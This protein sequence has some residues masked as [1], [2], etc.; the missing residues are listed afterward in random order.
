M[1]QGSFQAGLAAFTEQARKKADKNVRK[2]ILACL[3]G[4]IS[5]SPVDTGSFRLNWNIQ[6]KSPDLST[7]EYTG[8]PPKKKEPKPATMS[9]VN[10]ALTITYDMGD[11]VYIS[12]A[13][14]YANSIESGHSEQARIGVVA[15]T[16]REVESKIAGGALD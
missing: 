15:P 16:I 10:D 14:P 9:E 6:A 4:C 3:Q 12:N 13:L 11:L 2:T 7:K 1:R 5:R 8:E